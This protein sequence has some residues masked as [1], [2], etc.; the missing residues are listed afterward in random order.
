MRERWNRVKQWWCNKGMDTVLP[1]LIGLFGSIG[2]DALCRWVDGR[3][4]GG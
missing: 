2:M 3:W 4:F 1:F